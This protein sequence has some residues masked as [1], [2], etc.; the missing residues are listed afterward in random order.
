MSGDILAV[1]AQR[2]FKRSGG[3]SEQTFR[4]NYRFKRPDLLGPIFMD[5]VGCSGF[6]QIARKY[7]ISPQT[8]ALHS[9]R[10][11]RHCQLLHEHLR[12]RGPILEPLALD[13]FQSFEYSQYHPLL[14]H[15][16]AGK[17]SHFFHGFTDSYTMVNATFGVKW[18]DGKFITSLK[19][20]NLL[21]EQI[22]QHVF[23]DILKR[24]IFAEV[25]AT[26]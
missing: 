16:V 24:A 14:F 15:V 17:D 20:T 6:R 25:R 26:F 1:N 10:L 12:P 7:D 22:Q 4:V 23:G 18:A 5:L 8:A 9:A 21:N 13:S 2:L 3:F 11:G 19:G